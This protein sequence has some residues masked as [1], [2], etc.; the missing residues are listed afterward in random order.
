ME[1]NNNPQWAWLGL[2]KWSLSYS[3]GTRPSNVQ[4]M[5]P[6]DRAFLE[7]VMKEGIIDEAERMRFVLNKL[8]ETLETYQQ[9]KD[10][11]EADVDLEELEDLMLELRDI[12]E[13]IDF[14]RGFCAMKAVD[15]LLGCIQEERVPLTIRNG[16][17]GIISTLCQN[18]H[19]V[20]L[21]F[22]EKGALRVLSE[23]CFTN[24]GNGDFK[25]K[26]IQSMSA[27]VRN[28]ELAEDVMEKV[29][30]GPQLMLDA[31]QVHQPESLRK[32][33]I[34]F[35]RAF[36]TSDTSTRAR[37]RKFSSCVGYIADFYLTIDSAE[38][39]EL[40]LDL[41]NQI[42]TQKLSVNTILDRK[43]TLAGLGVQQIGALRKLEGEERDFA[44]VELEYWE[45][46]M[47]HIA[48]A[49]T[50]EDEVTMLLEDGTTCDPVQRTLQ[51]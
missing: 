4:M 17:L 9:G 23:L 10:S 5:S 40:G 24:E 16:C 30:Q 51:Q 36:T 44:C 45:S 28:H 22:L 1:S 39:R 6:E 32:R 21:E 15:F 14:A 43:D 11:A 3:D 46:L 47:V 25:A 48:R 34:F 42:L 19:P 41:L 31:L 49:D 13:Q 12:V 8:T 26:L 18:N 20:Q 37:V 33:A 35:L 50:D 29:E 38:I 2:L 27:I 7:E